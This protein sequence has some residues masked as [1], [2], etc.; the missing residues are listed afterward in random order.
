MPVFGRQR[1]P[2][3][4]LPDALLRRVKQFS[5]RL[6][7]EAITSMQDQ[8]PFVG[9]LDADQRASVQLLVQTAVVNFLEWLKD[10]EGD[11]RFSMEAFQV[12]PRTWPAG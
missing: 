10:P 8:L 11:I 9:D 4:P 3:D 1:Q 5:G 2:R 12:I 7:T 6:S